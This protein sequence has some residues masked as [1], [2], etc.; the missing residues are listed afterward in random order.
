MAKSSHVDSP[1][2]FGHRGMKFSDLDSES[3]T[4]EID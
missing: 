4:V 1:T 2:P 3:C